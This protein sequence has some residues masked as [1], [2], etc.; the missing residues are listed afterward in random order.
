MKIISPIFCDFGTPCIY[1]KKKLWHCKCH[2]VFQKLTTLVSLTT[3]SSAVNFG[4]L[5]MCFEGF[6]TLKLMNVGAKA[7]NSY[8]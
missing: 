5:Q 3:G 2:Q 4:E 1:T 7:L 8:Y 6:H